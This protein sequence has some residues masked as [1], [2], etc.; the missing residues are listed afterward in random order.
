MS[1]FTKYIYTHIIMN[2]IAILAADGFEEIE[3]KSPKIYLQ[4]KGFQVDIVSP[5]DIEFVRS[6]NHF[7]WG[8]SYPIDVHLAEA[9]PAVYEALILPGGTLS[10]DALRVLPKAL[11]FIKHFTNKRN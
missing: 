5:K 7:D 9:D 2:K 1:L 4:N 10:P 3:L 11:D 6:W 8:P